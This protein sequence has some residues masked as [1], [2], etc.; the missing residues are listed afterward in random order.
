MR[1]SV[2][3]ISAMRRFFSFARLVGV[4]FAAAALNASAAIPSILW[5]AISVDVKS[6]TMQRLRAETFL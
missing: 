4:F 5:P 3:V 1:Q 6:F 2:A